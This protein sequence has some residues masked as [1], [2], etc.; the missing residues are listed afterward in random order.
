VNPAIL[1]F[2]GIPPLQESA[3]V[4]GPNQALESGLLVQQG[5]DLANRHPELVV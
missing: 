1:S 4:I 2:A 3:E 5:V